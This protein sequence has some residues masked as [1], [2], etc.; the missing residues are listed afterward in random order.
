MQQV[1]ENIASEQMLVSSRRCGSI[2]F[3]AYGKLVATSELKCYLRNS[4]L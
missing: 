4:R 1:N 3:V 2:H